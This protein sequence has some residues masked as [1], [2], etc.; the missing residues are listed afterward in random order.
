MKLEDVQQAVKGSSAVVVSLGSAQQPEVVIEGT[1][2]TIEAMQREQ[3]KRIVVVSSM[4]VGDSQSQ[5]GWM[6]W[7]VSRALPL[8]RTALA[9]KEIQ[10][11]LVA[12]SSLGI[13]I[14]LCFSVQVLFGCVGGDSGETLPLST[15]I[16]VFVLF[17]F[18]LCCFRQTGRSCGQAD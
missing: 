6:F 15:A 8:L 10:E 4:G 1:K 12:E 5:I 17:C 7:L 13:I 14:C 16:F 2:H 9:N 18:V 3:V 11:K